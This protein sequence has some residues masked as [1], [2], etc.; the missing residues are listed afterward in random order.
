MAEESGN[1]VVYIN[2]NGEGFSQW[3]T[4]LEGETSLAFF[5]RMN[6]GSDP[7]NFTIRVNRDATTADYVLKAGDTISISPRKV[8][9][10]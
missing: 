9:G 4:I 2:A 7:K 10:A 1:R 6:P 5:Q 3:Q 8:A